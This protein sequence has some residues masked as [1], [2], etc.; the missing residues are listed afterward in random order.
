MKELVKY[1]LN[2]NSVLKYREIVSIF[3]RQHNRSL[4][5]CTFN[6][7]CAT[8][9]LTRRNIVSTQDLQGLVRNELC[10]SSSS[11]VGFRQMTEIINSKYNLNV[12][13]ENVQ[14]ALLEVDPQGVEDRRGKTINQRNYYTDGPG[15]FYHIDGNDKLKKWGFAIHGRIDGFSQKILWLVVATTNNDPLVVGNLFLNCGR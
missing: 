5:F 9:K 13:K 2:I 4:T 6:S 8:E 1:Y 11:L 3:N 12:S 10:T 7:I 14:L 15:D